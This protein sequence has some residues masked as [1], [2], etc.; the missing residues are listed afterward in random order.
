MFLIADSALGIKYYFPSF[1]ES[2]KRTLD[3]DQPWE[4]QQLPQPEII[5]IDEINLKSADC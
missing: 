4:G 2:V 1:G 3:E 5:P